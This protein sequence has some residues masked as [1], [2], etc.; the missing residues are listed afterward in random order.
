MERSRSGTNEQIR[1]ALGVCSKWVSDGRGDVRKDC[2]TCEYH[3]PGDP[4]GMNCGE[5]L[6]R[7]AAQLIDEQKTRIESLED[8]IRNMSR[9][10][11]RTS[12]REYNE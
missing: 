8:Q 11:V 6:M 4:A 1:H 12:Q 7:D 5:H 2:Q 10:L 9:D 3:D